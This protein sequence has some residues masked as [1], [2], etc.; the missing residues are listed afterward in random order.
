MDI[1][2]A[3]DHVTNECIEGACKIKG[4]KAAF[5]AWFSDFFNNRCVN[6]EF[7]G[8]TYKRYCAM[9]TPQGSTASP[10]FW[11]AIADELHESVE[12][13]GDVASEGF[14]D[15]TCFVIIG[16]NLDHIHRRMQMALD[17]AS[18]WAK[19]HNLEF[20]A[21]KTKVILYTWKQ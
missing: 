13:L 10:Y 8:K 7:K 18:L 9:G 3:F 2:G 17:L 20:S 5:I 15:D 11:N 1:K 19:S 16:N 14:A 6:F 4:C 12:G 21:S